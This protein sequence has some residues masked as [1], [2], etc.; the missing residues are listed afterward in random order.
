MPLERSI[1]YAVAVLGASLGVAACGSSNSG[2]SG[3]G[4][5]RSQALAF[6]QCMR[7]HGVPNFPDPRTNGGGGLLIQQKA[8][9]GASLTVNGVSVSSPAFQSAMRSC[10][11]YL[12]NGGHPPPL[13]ASRRAALLAFSRCMR[14]HGITNFPDPTFQNGGV[15]LR[16]GSS[17]GIDPSSPAF[18]AAQK[19]CGKNGPFRVQSVRPGG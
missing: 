8:G 18:Q 15:G 7:A 1:S 10:R 13:S 3:T 19:A 11:S 6:A 12:P 4:A 2:K 14:A 9:S 5:D 16:F 17:S